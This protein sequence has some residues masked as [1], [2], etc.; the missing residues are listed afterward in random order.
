M[1]LCQI[2][3]QCQK[4]IG[5]RQNFVNP[6]EPRDTRTHP[7]TQPKK[8]HIAGNLVESTRIELLPSSFENRSAFSLKIGILVFWEWEKN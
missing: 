4:F 6:R 7:H 5:P 1:P 3:D 2:L 8:S